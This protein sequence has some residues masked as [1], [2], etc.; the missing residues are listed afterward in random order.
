MDTPVGTASASIERRTVIAAADSVLAAEIRHSA[1]LLGGAL[2]LM[3]SLAVLMLMLTGF[4][5]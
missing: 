4:G 3:G 1:L 2:G 5:G